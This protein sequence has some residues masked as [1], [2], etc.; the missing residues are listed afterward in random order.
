MS[1][2]FFNC[3][4]SVNEDEDCYCNIREDGEIVYIK[5]KGCTVISN[6]DYQEL[7]KLKEDQCT[8]ICPFDS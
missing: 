1:K 7:L 2:N 3:H 5:M 6:K 8:Y 4:F